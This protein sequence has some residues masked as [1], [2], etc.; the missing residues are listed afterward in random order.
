MIICGRTFHEDN[1]VINV[2]RTVAVPRNSD[3]GRG[4]SLPD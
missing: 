2:E 1:N 3:L 4:Q